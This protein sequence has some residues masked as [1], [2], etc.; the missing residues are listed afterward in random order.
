MTKARKVTQRSGSNHYKATPYSLRSFQSKIMKD[1][2]NKKQKKESEKKDY[3]DARCSVCMEYPHNAVLLL[4]SSHHKGCR[5][6]MCAT[7]YR[8]SN[9]LDQYKKAYLKEKED[10]ESPD[11]S[12]VDPSDSGLMCPLC[13]GQVKGWTVVERARKFLNSKKRSCMQDDC[14]FVG[15]YRD[16]RKHVREDHPLACPLEVDPSLAEKWKK[17]ENDM[18]LNDVMS[19]ISS[20]MPGSIV[21]GDY[22]IEGNFRGFSRDM[23]MDNY[24]D[25]VL[26]RLGSRTSRGSYAILER[27]RQSVD[28]DGGGAAT[29]RVRNYI[30]RIARRQGRLVLGGPRRRRGRGVDM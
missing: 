14:S 16:L 25:N 2:H 24:L 12:S 5:P 21:M 23:E 10:S 17:L 29:G 22:V 11:G 26:F 15:S 13:R 4:C 8:Y 20:T 7:S 30:P 6:Y 28:D 27:G 1:A 19:T 3:K 9:C 18:E